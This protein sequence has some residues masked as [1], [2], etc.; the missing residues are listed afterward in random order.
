MA[1]KTLPGT[2][3]NRQTLI[4][5]ASDAIMHDPAQR[6]AF[7][8][9]PA[10]FLK[11]AGV[12]IRGTVDLTDRDKEIIRMVA[13]PQVAS[14]YKAG[15]ITKLSQYLRTAY[16][17]L[18][19]DPARVAWTVADFEVAIEAVA[20]AVGVFVVGVRPPEVFTEIGRVEAVLS[21]RLQAVEAG[22]AALQAQLNAGS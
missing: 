6:A 4:D 11:T 7:L 15:D 17:G 8:A 22:L 18:V 5:A 19:N 2:P 9:D 10:A 20:I 21:A 12:P 16:A 3:H 13:D 14:I 1:D